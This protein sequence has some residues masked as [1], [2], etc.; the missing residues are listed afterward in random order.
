MY[1]S[2]SETHTWTTLP[3]MNR[4]RYRWSGSFMD[5]KFCVIGAVSSN[6]ETLLG[7]PPLLAVVNNELYAADYSENNDLK[8]YDK[9]DN[10]WIPRGK[11]PV[12]S[13]NKGSD[14]G[15]RA[16]GDRLIVIGPPNNSSDDKVVELHSWTPD[17]QPPVWNLFATRPYRGDH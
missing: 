7:N 17:G 11:L 8:K 12:Q 6:R 15:F 10:K 3:S 2:E 13:T 9:L 16:C 1:D 14:M 5:G 4:A